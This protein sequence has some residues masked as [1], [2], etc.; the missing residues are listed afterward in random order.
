L[1]GDLL[2]VGVSAPDVANG[3]YGGRLHRIGVDGTAARPWSQGE[4]DSRPALSPDGRWLA[5]LRAESESRP[6]L[7]LQPVDG[8]DARRLTDLPLGVADLVWAPDSTRIAFTARI[9]EPGRYG[10]PVE[11]GAEA[12]KPDAEAPRRIT[13][14]DYRIDDVGFR[15]DRHVRLFVVD[16]PDASGEP[17]EPVELTDGRCD[18]ADPAWTPDGGHVLFS[19]PRELDLEPTRHDDVYAVSSDGGEPVLVL[20]SSG[21]AGRLTVLP[22]GT[23]LFIGNTFEADDSAAQSEGLWT[24]PVRLDGSTPS[25]RRLTDLSV[26]CERS[27][28]RPVVVDGAALVAVRD[29]GAVHL[30][31][32]PLDAEEL[33]LDQLPVVLGE[34]AGVLAFT[35]Q[36]GRIAAVVSTPDSPGEVVVVDDAGTRTVTDFAAELRGTGLRP[37][38]ELSG[39]SADGHP[40]HGF[41][42]LPAGPGP[43]PVL[44]HVHGGPFS[45]HGW[46]FFDE[47]QVYAAAGYAVVLPNPRG[48]AGYG[49]AHG[50]AVVK[51]FGSKDAEDV[52]AVLDVALTRPECDAER[53]GVMGGSYGGFMT[54]W[55]SA[56]HG[57]RFRAAWSERA[58]NAWDSFAGSSDIGSHFTDAYIGADVATQRDRSPLTYADRIRLPFLVMH[59]EQDWRCPLEQG[60][61]MFVALHRNGVEVE[62]LLFPGEGH[63]LTRGGKPQHRVQRLDAVLEWWSRHLK[64][65]G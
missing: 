55:L 19:A 18:V 22:D 36:G 49:Y 53:V 38:T 57:E 15:R 4:R 3:R 63:E 10:T 42:V 56:H 40:V 33:P 39:T 2:L 50:R 43:H 25:P 54:S 37:V 30:C 61:R 35:A 16:V 41:L 23:L 5:F 1:H 65:T 64:S 47:A 21:A 32:V 44:L 9:P 51:A 29:R 24:V 27:A 34:H 48:S 45:F 28:G 60:Q 31:R 26:D 13:R 14:E 20:R 6:Q 11:T 17:T 7:V 59:S 58:V 8:G 52:L 62:F 46:K 12:P